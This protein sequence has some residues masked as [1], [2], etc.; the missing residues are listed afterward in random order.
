MKVIL[1]QFRIDTNAVLYFSKFKFD[2]VLKDGNYYFPGIE[3]LNFNYAVKVPLNKDYHI[4]RKNFLNK[5][6]LTAWT[7]D[8]T[9]S[10]L[11]FIETMVW[12]KDNR[13]S[14]IGAFASIIISFIK[15][16]KFKDKK[17][18]DALQESIKKFLIK[19]I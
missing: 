12:C 1:M 9:L 11:D 16:M 14:R 13:R 10:G 18:A 2:T 8:W 7:T 3:K 17:D 19:K 15:K 5:Q 4:E 6:L